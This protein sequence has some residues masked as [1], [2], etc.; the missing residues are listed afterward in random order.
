MTTENK[1]VTTYLPKAVEESLT[2]YCTKN[3]L[4]RTS[5]Q[6]NEIPSL[7]S[8]IVEVLKDYFS[9]TSDDSIKSYFSEQIELKLMEKVRNFFT[10]IEDRLSGV[11]LK[12]SD[13]VMY[14]NKVTIEQLTGQELS[15]STQLFIPN[16][17]E[18]HAEVRLENK[19]ANNDLIQPIQGKLLVL[20]LGTDRAG[21]S[22]RKKKLSEVGFSSWMQQRDIDHIRWVSLSDPNGRSKGYIPADNTP[23]ELLDRLR[24]WILENQDV[25][26]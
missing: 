8:A 16:I 25:K 24:S 5:K 20:R 1:A 17:E 7:G 19:D 11:E 22:T 6:G 15:D 14:S 13:L 26:S 9:V 23:S 18:S 3:G 12:V 2:K 4:T 21:L 10:S